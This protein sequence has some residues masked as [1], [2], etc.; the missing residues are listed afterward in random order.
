MHGF[1]SVISEQ[2]CFSQSEPTL[3][4]FMIGSWCRVFSYVVI[5]ASLLFSRSGDFIHPAVTSILEPFCLPFLD[6]S[7]FSVFWRVAS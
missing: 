2:G 5:Y 7:V 1:W 3:I 4:V 6:N